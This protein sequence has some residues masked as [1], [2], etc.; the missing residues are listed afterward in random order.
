MN[1]TELAEKLGGKIVSGENGRDRPVRGVYCCDLLSRVMAR[2]AGG[3]A[4]ITVHTH[5]NTVAAASFA[6]LACIIIPEG[7]ETEDATVKRAAGENIP[8]IT[9]ELSAYKVCCIA[10]GCG[11]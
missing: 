6:E 11:L 3:D 8:V 2:A 4:W 5:I 9:T 10:C 7:I 1:V